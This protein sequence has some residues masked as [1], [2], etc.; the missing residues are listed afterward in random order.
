MHAAWRSPPAWRRVLRVRRRL[1]VLAMLASA[2][3]VGAFGGSVAVAA[4]GADGGRAPGP[5]AVTTSEPA[6]TPTTCVAAP[7]PVA[8]SGDADPGAVTVTF[9][10]P[11][12]R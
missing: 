10:V 2:V 7:A 1:G 3:T 12:C 4:L 11:D 6:T 8:S 5:R 9:V